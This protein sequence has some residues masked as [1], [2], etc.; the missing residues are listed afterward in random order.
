MSADLLAEFGN[1]AS[2]N[3][4]AGSSRQGAVNSH[5]SSLVPDL[6]T[7]EDTSLSKIPSEDLWDF[8]D[9]QKAQTDNSNNDVLFDATLE[10]FS[11]DE[12]DWGEFETADSKST[13]VYGG[14]HLMDSL[15][16]LSI[17]EEPNPKNSNRPGKPV[18]G[19]PNTLSSSLTLKRAKIPIEDESFEEWADFTDGP[20]I[21]PADADAS[22]NS[23]AQKVSNNGRVAVQSP[24]APEKREV[25]TL[26]SQPAPS[27]SAAHVRPT[28]IPPPSIL[29]ELFPR[30]FEQL[31]KE[32][33][34]AKN[35]PQKEEQVEAVALSILYTLKAAA[36]VVAGRPLRWKRDA[37]LSQSMRIGPAR[38]GKAG[39]MK[40]STVNK[41]ED[42]KEQQ[43]SVDVINMWRDRSAFFN[44]ILQAAGKRPVQ[45]I[46]ENARAMPEQGALKAPHACA[47]CGLK[48]DE[49][50]SK[51][52]DNVEDSFG[53]WW[54]DHW[55][56]T[57]CRQFWETN[58]IL[59]NQR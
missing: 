33:A 58:M 27:T 20:P 50:L 52:D 49:R 19:I 22:K 12:S 10:R 7:L 56:H 38:S 47:L 43:E 29:L 15:D 28:N 30:L 53:E 1:G 25:R 34:E 4:A 39:G 46:Q 3:Q 42:I 18:D 2:H 57:D 23:N 35:P 37:I 41:N 21:E 48:R 31:R 6:D 17:K 59:L 45:V 16:S 51:I 8:G 11:D 44:S 36:R 32:G 9:F 5:T 55:G 26:Q 13:T 40:L 54:T 24:F 14:L